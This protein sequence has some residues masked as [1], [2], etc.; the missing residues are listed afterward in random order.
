MLVGFVVQVKDLRD[1]FILEIRELAWIW[2]VCHLKCF[3]VVILSTLGL[4]G[5][6]PVFF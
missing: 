6:I 3:V 2:I 5:L 4:N 1:W